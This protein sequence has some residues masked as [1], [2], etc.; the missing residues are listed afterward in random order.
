MFFSF[1]GKRN[2]FSKLLTV[3]FVE[4]KK[5]NLI[6]TLFV[7]VYDFIRAATNSY[8]H[9]DKQSIIIQSAF[10]CPTN[11]NQKRFYLLSKNRKAENPHI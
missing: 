8:F 3:R 10:V 9:Y 4:K 11:Q 2:L 6:G 1:F 5:S 7:K